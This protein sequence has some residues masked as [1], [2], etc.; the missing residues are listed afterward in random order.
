MI[1]NPCHGNS[2]CYMVS[3]FMQIWPKS[4]GATLA[5]EG[6]RVGLDFA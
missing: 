6:N 4:E 3:A 5:C 2:T 1:G